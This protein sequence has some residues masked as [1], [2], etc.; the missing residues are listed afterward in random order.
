MGIIKKLQRKVMLTL[1]DNPYFYHKANHLLE[2]L[3]EVEK[4]LNNLG[5]SKQH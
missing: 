5:K 4:T 3:K 1:Y 2:H